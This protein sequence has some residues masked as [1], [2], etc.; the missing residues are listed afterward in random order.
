MS[1]SKIIICKGILRQVFIRVYTLEIQSVMLVFSTQLCEPSLWFNSSPPSL[2]QSTEYYSVHTVC[3]WEG[4]RM[5][6]PVGDHI[7]QEFN[8]LYVTRFRTYRI[9]R[10]PQ[11]KTW[12]RR[13]PQE[14][15]TS[16]KVH[17]QVN[18]FYNNILLW[19][20]ERRTKGAVRWSI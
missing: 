11:T 10:P 15:N 1:S 19:R 4:V 9:A 13:G 17:F 8:T 6:S 16:R 14:I 12:E 3:G 7:L 18:L 5:L 20:L 2:P